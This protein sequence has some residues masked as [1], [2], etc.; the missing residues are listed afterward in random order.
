[1][2]QILFMAD[3]LEYRMLEYKYDFFVIH[4]GVNLTKNKKLNFKFN[5]KSLVFGT[6]TPFLYTIELDTLYFS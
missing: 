6:C 3:V 2:P 1:M 5:L 4:L